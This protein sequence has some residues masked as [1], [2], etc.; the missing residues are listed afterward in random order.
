MRSFDF[1][2]LA[3][4]EYMRQALE[5]ALRIYPPLWLMTRR[6]LHDDYLGEYFV[7]DGTSIYISPCILHGTLRECPA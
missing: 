3:G 5:E 6:A 7:P 2:S 4:L 1:E